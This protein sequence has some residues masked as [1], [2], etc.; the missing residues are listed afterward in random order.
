MKYLVSNKNRII[1]ATIGAILMIYTNIDKP[2]YLGCIAGSLMVIGAALNIY[3][4]CVHKGKMPVPKHIELTEKHKPLYIQPDKSH[5]LADRFR[6]T[7]PFT[8]YETYLSVAE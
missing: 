4:L 2:T 7:I 5:V 6:L 8:P 1:L 3:V